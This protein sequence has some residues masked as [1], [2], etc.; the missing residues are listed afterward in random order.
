MDKIVIFCKTFIRDIDK[1]GI[2]LE[3]I[4]KYNV[5]NISFYVSIPYTDIPKFINRFGNESYTII[6]DYEIYNIN[7]Q[8]ALNQQVIKLRFWKLNLCLNYVVIDSDSYFIKDFSEHD[9][10]YDNKTPYTVMH[11]QKELF[12][13]LSF[14]DK[15]IHKKSYE[16]YL[17]ERKNVMTEFIRNGHFFDFGPTPCIWSSLV[18]Q[19][20]EK[21]YLEPEK[22]GY[23]DLI[24]KSPSELT[25][26]GE[27][28]LKDKTIPIIPIEP[29]FK[30]FHYKSQYLQLKKN[31]V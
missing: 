14:Y 3:S 9:F 27:W 11:Q 5:D 7:E 8:S 21:N 20:L 15:K 24:I 28:L 12:S 4:K 16:Y 25:W 30:V 18:L 31:K 22:I 29:V 26:Y 10:L 1:F 23:K 13:W 2:L 19:S 6:N 17:Y